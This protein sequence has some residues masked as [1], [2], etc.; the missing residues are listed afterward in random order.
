MRKKTLKKWQAI[1]QQQSNSGLPVS[2]FC[3]TNRLSIT[4]FYKYKKELSK[5][6]NSGSAEPVANNSFVKIQPPKISNSGERI[7]I[8][9]QQSI[10]S[11][12]TTLEPDWIA[13]LLKALA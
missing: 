3:K 9:H 7:K 1:I 8:Q 2:R 4:C 12:P 6:A 5:S 13:N 11:L 10:L